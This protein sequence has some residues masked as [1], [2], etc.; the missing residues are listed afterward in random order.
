MKSKLISVVVPVYNE[1]AGIID[2][3]DEQLGPVLN[4]LKYETEVILVNDGSRDKTLE[5][6]DKTKMRKKKKYWTS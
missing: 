2:F 5:K 3:L 4:E 1:E 6:I